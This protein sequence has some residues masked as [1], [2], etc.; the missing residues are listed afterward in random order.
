MHDLMV[1][2]RQKSA[3]YPAMPVEMQNAANSTHGWAIPLKIAAE[4][5][6]DSFAI[7]ET[8]AFPLKPFITLIVSKPNGCCTL[9]ASRS[10]EKIPS[11][12][13]LESTSQRLTLRSHATNCFSPALTQLP[14]Q[15][16]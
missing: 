10:D 3:I 4:T 9:T 6:H 16:I 1:H 5:H 8:S 14:L 13:S 12:V 15:K 2:R 11:P 7:S